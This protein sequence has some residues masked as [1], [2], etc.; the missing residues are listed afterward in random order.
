MEVELKYGF[1]SERTFQQ[2][3]E[4]TALGG[5][6]LEAGHVLEV[7]DR[8]LDTEDRTLLQAGYAC[9]IRRENGRHLA[10][11][12]GLGDA[13][14]AYHRR[15]EH[16]IELAE[17]L[18]PPDWP[19]APA[20]DLVLS[21]CGER[22]L[23]PLLDVS[24]ERHRRRLCDGDRAV[25]EVSL[26]RV[27]YYD[28]EEERASGLEF[29]AELLPSGN[30]EDLERLAAELDG[31]EGLVP[32]LESKFE[33][34]L[35]LLAGRQPADWVAPGTEAAFAPP[36][37][38]KLRQPH[39][40]PDDPMSEAGRK[41]LRYHF[42][43]MV[44]HEPGTRLGQD[45]EALHDMRVAT[46]RMRAA[47]RVFGDYFDARAVA[48]YLKGLKR[49]GRALGPVRDLDVLKEKAQAYVDTLPEP[50]KEGL[51]G[52][53][54]AIDQHREAARRRMLRHLDSRK[55]TRFKE[56]FG[57]F[58]HSEGLGSLPVTSGDGEPRPFRLRHVA[59]MAVYERLGAVRAY[60]EWVVVPD[61]P[62]ERL[63][64]LRIACKRLRY[65]L[66]F[67]EQVLG[68]ETR[69]A[70]KQVVAVQDHLGALQDAVVA[71]DILREFLATG[72]WG[73]GAGTPLPGRGAS[74]PGVEAYLEAR[75]AEVRHLVETFP[76]VW[77]QITA[78]E[79]SHTMAGIVAG[80]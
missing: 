49:T 53:F 12:K 76:Q 39:L 68:P 28:G 55:Y 69:A 80:P 72:S 42:Q 74:S 45:A 5:F 26:D 6:R 75:H 18:P 15:I 22:P 2:L 71:S 29:E 41:I 59:P 60:D 8:Y 51:E 40:D 50:K 3:L 43:V 33:Q 14:G 25:A 7:R 37:Q 46:R 64:A 57:L 21:L 23:L 20:R 11:V 30:P 35:A 38:A 54:A 13:S 9:R 16:E 78:S 52:L 17:P 56:R 19:P 10:T 70:I 73:K 77:Q 58:L 63:H 48:P 47:F 34:G 44:Y 27:R 67:F 36:R 66:E 79:F 65:T 62:L 32:R 4:A 24:Q 61:P 1:C 31:R